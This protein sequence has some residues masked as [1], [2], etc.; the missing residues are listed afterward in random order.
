MFP[1]YLSPTNVL[2]RKSYSRIGGKNSDNRGQ[3]SPVIVGVENRNIIGGKN[4]DRSRNVFK[5]PSILFKNLVNNLA[6]TKTVNSL[7]HKRD[8]NDIG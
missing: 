3:E 5:N 2:Y 6:A 1:L 7:Q 4:R 8:S